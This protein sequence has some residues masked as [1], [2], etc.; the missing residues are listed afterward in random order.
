MSINL[1]LI[2]VREKRT[3][4]R[5]VGGSEFHNLLKYNCLSVVLNEELD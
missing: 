3:R 4:L 5:S 1:L 2:M